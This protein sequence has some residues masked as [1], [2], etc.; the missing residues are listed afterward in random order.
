MSPEPLRAAG[1]RR[2]GARREGRA[3]CI[4]RRSS[5]LRAHD[6][7]DARKPCY[8]TAPCLQASPR[9]ASLESS[10]GM[11]RARSAHISTAP[12]ALRARLPI[13]VF[14]ARSGA[15]ALRKIPPRKRARAS[16]RMHRPPAKLGWARCR[17]MTRG[18]LPGGAS[19][20]AQRPAGNDAL[21]WANRKRS[22]RCLARAREVGKRQA[23]TSRAHAPRHGGGGPRACRNRPNPHTAACSLCWRVRTRPQPA[24]TPA[25]AGG[26]HKPPHTDTSALHAARQALLAGAS[27]QGCLGQKSS[28][29]RGTQHGAARRTPEIMHACLRARPPGL[30]RLFCGN[31]ERAHPPVGS[32]CQAGERAVLL[33]MQEAVKA[34]SSLAANISPRQ[35][36]RA[37]PARAAHSGNCERAGAR[38]P[39]G[40]RARSTIFRSMSARRHN[41]RRAAA[42]PGRPNLGRANG[43]SQ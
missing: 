9:A 4:L 27:G 31:R 6:H 33:L 18:T 25:E 5:S 32:A 34:N 2:E 8:E 26:T 23:R 21:R 15:R 16:C 10:V 11:Q 7:G 42:R 30:A 14:W 1:A 3:P 39:P 35:R 29:R 13:V 12:R 40:A 37:A 43:A 19:D 17:R 28:A 38:A 36:A 20:W 24:T 22:F 41:R